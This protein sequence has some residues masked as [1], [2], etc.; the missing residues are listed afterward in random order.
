VHKTAVSVSIP[1]AIEPPNNATLPRWYN[2]RKN[3]YGPVNFYTR[4]TIFT[5]ISIFEIY[6]VN[7]MYEKYSFFIVF[8][9]QKNTHRL[10][11]NSFEQTIHLIYSKIHQQSRPIESKYGVNIQILGRRANRFS[12]NMLQKAQVLWLQP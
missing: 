5:F 1:A 8:S 7:I 4:Y 3:I 11:T 2:N 10:Y 6:D 12:L 9:A